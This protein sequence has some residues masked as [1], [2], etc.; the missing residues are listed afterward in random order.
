MKIRGLKNALFIITEYFFIDFRV[1]GQTADGSPAIISFTRH[2][3]IIERFGTKMLIG[4]D[5]LNP[6]MMVPDIGK[7]NLTIGNCKNRTVKLNVNN[8]GP[9]IKL[10]VRFNG[11]IK[12]PAKFNLIIFF[13]L[14]GKNFLAKRY[15]MIIH[16]KIDQLGNDGGVLS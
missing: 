10:V 16:H 2:V 1:P 9:P 13:K 8:I 3:Y 4:N 11:T 5:I 6:E 7:S 15:F 12:I 14:R